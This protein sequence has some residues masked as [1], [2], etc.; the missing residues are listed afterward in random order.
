MEREDAVYHKLLI[1]SCLDDGYDE[2]LNF[3]LESENPL[4]NIVLELACCGSDINKT[5]SV[6]HNF[7]MEQPFDEAVVC[8]RLRAYFQD[9]YYTNRMSFDEF[10]KLSP[11]VIKI[12][13]CLA[14]PLN[15]LPISHPVYEKLVKHYDYLEI[16]PHNHP[17]QKA[18]NVHLA[19]LSEK[20]KKPL[21]AGTDTHSLNSY[22]AECRTILLKAKLDVWI[23]DFYGKEIE[24][25]IK[26]YLTHVGGNFGIT[27]T[28][29][30]GKKIPHSV[31]MA[32]EKE[33]EA[34]FLYLLSHEF[35]HPMTKEIVEELHKNEKILLQK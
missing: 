13:A 11:N 32:N 28:S 8:D 31:I 34:G 35:S 1:M 21:I 9:A 27:F 30:D 15:K 29:P 6:L 25:N 26:L 19:T 17:D 20:Y 7:C 22:K 3:Y 2:W 12:S 4:S 10:F 33:N 16:Q 5:I 24:D 23:E 14:S 18:Y